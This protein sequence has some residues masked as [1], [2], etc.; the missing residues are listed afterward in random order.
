MTKRLIHITLLLFFSFAI[1][2]CK[3]E[4]L[5]PVDLSNDYYPSNI[6]HWVTYK[7]D[8]TLYNDNDGSVT[9]YHYTIKEFI[10]SKYLD[11]QNR[12]TLRIER[13]INT[14]SSWR[15]CDVWASNLTLTT[16]EKVEENI[17][18]V[19]L[20]FPIVNGQVWNGNAF[21]SLEP[22]EYKYA[23]VFHPYTVDGI[24]FDSTVTIIQAND[25][26][27]NTKYQL[28]VYA[29]NIGLIYKRY[30]DVKT[31]FPFHPDSIVKGTD[32]TYKII[33]FG[34]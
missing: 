3:H 32:Y 8:S 22:Q 24:T 7:V 1:F 10:E 4:T 9:N 28:E 23:N 18:F 11:I 27:Q 5:K 6:G 12:P 29:K 19:K 26:I 25:T 16:A 33:D 20:I 21:N 30:K 34:N 14:D 31:D 15:I 17:R 13:F 2:S